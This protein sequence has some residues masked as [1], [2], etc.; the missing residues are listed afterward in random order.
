MIMGD[1]AA[2]EKRIASVFRADRAPRVGKASLQAYRTYLLQH[3]DKNAVLTG[4]EDFL[5]EEFYVFGPGDKKEYEKLKKTRPSYSDHFAFIDIPKKTIGGHDLIT[6]VKRLSDGKKFEIG[7]SWLTTKKK[8]TKAYQVLDDF[9]T[10][11]VNC[12]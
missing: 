12:Q 3:F 2:A 6:R 7:L 9:A 10:W 5:W 8:R 4:R 11:I 1:H